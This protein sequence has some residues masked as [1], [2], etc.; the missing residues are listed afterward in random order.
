MLDTMYKIVRQEARDYAFQLRIPE[1]VKVTAVAPTGS[2]A[3]LPGV[4]E[5]IHP[6]YARWF[7]RRVRFSLR[8]PAQANQVLEFQAQ[9]FTVETDVYDQSGQTAVVVFPT[10][11]ILVEQVR[12]LGWDESLVQSA[13]EISVWDMLQVQRHYQEHWADNAISYTVNIPEGA[14]SADELSETLACFLP[15]LKGTTIMVDATRPQ[16]PYTRITHEQYTV[17]AA[18]NVED[19][20]DESCSSGA[21]PI[22]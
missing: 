15:Y 17:A 9:G 7:E 5:G 16:A 1:P 22:R 11:D 2:V 3:K 14:V 21:C 18:K 20:T 13:D 10:E 6:I 8:D 12:A 19:G 4:T